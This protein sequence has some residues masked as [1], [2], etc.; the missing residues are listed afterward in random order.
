MYTG[1]SKRWGERGSVA[2]ALAVVLFLLRVEGRLVGDALAH[3]VA[4]SEGVDTVLDVLA[5]VGL[6]AH[7]VGRV[8]VLLDILKRGVPTLI[9]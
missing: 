4:L 8:T 7:D 3:G 5:E 6:V 1:A 9:V 2:V